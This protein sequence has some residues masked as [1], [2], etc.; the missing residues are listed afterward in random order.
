M[1]SRVSLGMGRPRGGGGRRRAGHGRERNRPRTRSGAGQVT[2][3]AGSAAA[4]LVEALGEAAGVALLGPGQRLEPLG[5]LLEALV[6][7]G[8]GEAGVH[9]GVLVGLAGDG[10]LQVLGGAADRL[11][12]G[13][14][15]DLL[16]EVEVPEGVTGL[17]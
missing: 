14:V 5:D 13:G 4:D 8:L 6:A 10:R 12:R 2:G 15:T 17:A 11:A 9:L 3:D 7:G 16:Q 1:S